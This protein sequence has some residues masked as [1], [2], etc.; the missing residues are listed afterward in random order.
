MRLGGYINLVEANQ[1]SKYLKPP[2][3]KIKIIIMAPTK[4]REGERGYDGANAILRTK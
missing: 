2:T 4:R 1:I 3:L